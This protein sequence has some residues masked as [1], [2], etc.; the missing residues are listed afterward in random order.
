M[1]ACL[2]PLVADLTPGEQCDRDAQQDTAS[3]FCLTS[4]IHI[5]WHAHA[6]RWR[7]DMAW[8]RRGRLACS[9]A[10]GR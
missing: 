9:L 1:D 2:V 7:H 4:H 10:A 6:W 5:A 3:P 8:W